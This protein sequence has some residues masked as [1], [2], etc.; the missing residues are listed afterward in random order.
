MSD[1]VDMKEIKQTI[2]SNLA[3]EYIFIPHPEAKRPGTYSED[4]L[5]EAGFLHIQ[6]TLFEML[7]WTGLQEIDQGSVWGILDELSRHRQ[8]KIFDINIGGNLSH[9]DVQVRAEIGRGLKK[10]TASGWV[11]DTV[12][13]YWDSPPSKKDFLWGGRTI[14][15]PSA[16]VKKLRGQLDADLRARH[17]GNSRAIEIEREMRKIDREA[18][19][20]L[21][22]QIARLIEQK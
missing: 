10:S 17:G 15:K 7:T 19:L 3:A 14:E 16:V 22:Q 2:I 6:S 18:A 9:L 20:E 4:H 12:V 11:I 21:R 8:I 13:Y 1:T 5:S